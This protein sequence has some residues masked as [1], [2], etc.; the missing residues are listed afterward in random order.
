[1]VHAVFDD[2][3]ALDSIAGG[4]GQNSEPRTAINDEVIVLEKITPFIRKVTGRELKKIYQSRSYGGTKDSFVDLTQRE[5]T[6]FGRYNYDATIEASDFLGLHYSQG[7]FHSRPT[8]DRY[9]DLVDE[10]GSI[11]QFNI[12]VRTIQSLVPEKINFPEQVTLT[13]WVLPDDKENSSIVVQVPDFFKSIHDSFMP[14]IKEVY[15]LLPNIQENRDTDNDSHN[16][17]V[18]AYVRAIFL[19][20]FKDS[21]YQSLYDR[22]IKEFSVDQ[23]ISS[24]FEINTRTRSSYYSFALDNEISEYIGIE[25]VTGINVRSYIRQNA[26]AALTFRVPVDGHAGKSI[27]PRDASSETGDESSETGD[28]DQGDGTTLG[29]LTQMARERAQGA[30]S[31]VKGAA[32]ALM[33]TNQPSD[34]GRDESDG[35]RSDAGSDHGDNRSVKS[36]KSLISVQNE[37]ILG[38]QAEHGTFPTGENP[39][40]TPN[41]ESS[42]DPDKIPSLDVEQLPTS[43]SD[44]PFADGTGGPDLLPLGS[45]NS[46]EQG[47]EAPQADTPPQGKQPTELSFGNADFASALQEQLGRLSTPKPPGAQEQQPQGAQSADSRSGNAGLL[48]EI[49]EKSSQLRSQQSSQLSTPEPESNSPKPGGIF[50][51]LAGKIPMFSRVQGYELK[52]LLNGENVDFDGAKAILSLFDSSLADSVGKEDDGLWNDEF[53]KSVNAI[54]LE[55]PILDY[56]VK[57]IQLVENWITNVGNKGIRAG[58]VTDV[59]RVLGIDDPNKLGSQSEKANNYGRTAILFAIVMNAWQGAIPMD[60]TTM[61]NEGIKTLEDFAQ[62]I[63]KTY[64]ITDE[65]ALSKIQGEESTTKGIF[66]KMFY[67]AIRSIEE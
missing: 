16:K 51:Q 29:S 43:I 40:K 24:L 27:E 11:D 36:F 42:I 22:L 61:I 65:D 52:Q 21:L 15:E 63:I 55:E 41:E 14:L 53:D 47:S 13:D 23:V 49:R 31:A 4:F 32:R 20:N 8:L 57:N 50:G 33:D 58:G 54:T 37:E 10:I 67:K 56:F 60:N 39:D 45:S 46:E 66:S 25:G 59:A 62:K 35:D 1:M 17:E 3:T 18:F 5:E 9:D 34:D 44:D 64:K 30:I 6:P 7:V 2:D 48:Q 38:E 12:Q 26:V 28:S 19:L